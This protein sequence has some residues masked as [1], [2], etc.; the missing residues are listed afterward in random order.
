MEILSI[1]FYFLVVC[2]II[3]FWSSSSNIRIFLPT[4]NDGKSRLRHKSY[5]VLIE[6]PRYSESCF[7]VRTLGLY[8]KSPS[9]FPLLPKAPIPLSDEIALS[10]SY[11]ISSISTVG[12]G[13]TNAW[14]IAFSYG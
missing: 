9:Y 10:S 12:T 1:F 6:H 13:I 8:I 3:H 11:V 2:L 4:L 14:Q 7:G 5:V